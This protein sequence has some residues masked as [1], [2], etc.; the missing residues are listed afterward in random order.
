MKWEKQ[1]DVDLT[2]IVFQGENWIH[3]ALDRG[4]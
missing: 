3:M 2:K 1:L 4:Q